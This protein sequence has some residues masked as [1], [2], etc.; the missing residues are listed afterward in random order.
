VRA[1]LGA[2]PGR[3]ARLVLTESLL[4]AALGA[5]AALLLASW[6]AG[7][8]HSLV[9]E[10]LSHVGAIRIDALVLAFNAILAGGM[11]VVTGLTSIAAV[12]SSGLVCRL[13]AGGGRSVTNRQRL[14]RSLLS[15]E[16]A[17]RLSSS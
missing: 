17:V 13:H 16:V 3:L 1:A 12:R 15:A 14:R 4:L 6:S 8:A 11:G 7:V 5:V 10:Q 2:G 9:A